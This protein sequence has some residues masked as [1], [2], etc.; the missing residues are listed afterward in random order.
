MKKSEYTIKHSPR[1]E[2]RLDITLF[3][4]SP[5][6]SFVLRVFSATFKKK[7][8]VWLSFH[9]QLAW[10]KAKQ[11]ARRLYTSVTFRTTLKQIALWTNTRAESAEREKSRETDKRALQ[12]GRQTGSFLFYPYLSYWLYIN[13]SVAH[14]RS[15]SSLSLLSLTLINF[16]LS[17]VNHP[18]LPQPQQLCGGGRVDVKIFGSHL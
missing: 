4:K 17:A 18:S 5:S 13:T 8:K 16:S 10:R 6:A 2:V 1:Y 7:S 15:H 3:E 14:T 11:T 12:A 9:M